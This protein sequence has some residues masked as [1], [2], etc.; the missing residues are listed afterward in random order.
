VDTLKYKIFK[1]NATQD[2][3]RAEILAIREEAQGSRAQLEILRN[4]FKK[5]Q[6]F[7]KRSATLS[8]TIGDNI[9]HA[10]PNLYFFNQ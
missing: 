8:K 1:A 7:L 2:S 10:M 9:F 3:P 5:F 4:S 6:E